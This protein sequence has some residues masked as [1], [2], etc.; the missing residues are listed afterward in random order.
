M[1]VTIRKISQVELSTV[2]SVNSAYYNYGT[3]KARVL[4]IPLAQLINKWQ[5]DGQ[6]EIYETK[7]ER[8]WGRIKSSY[9]DALGREISQYETL[10]HGR[11]SPLTGDPLVVITFKDNP[12]SPDPIL[13]IEFLIEHDQMFGREDTGAKKNEKIMKII[14]DEVERR[15]KLSNK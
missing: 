1:T 7:S 5:T 13:V 3:D 6:V 8:T 2:F 4:S 15:S 9:R 12:I 14:R 10:Y 11:V